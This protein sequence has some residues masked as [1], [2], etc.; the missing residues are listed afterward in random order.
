MCVSLFI[1]FHIGTFEKIDEAVKISSSG[2][3]NWRASDERDFIR[4]NSIEKLGIFVYIYIC[5]DVCMCTLT[6]A[7]LC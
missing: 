3:I 6:L 5:G 7:F 1:C 4:G 2:S